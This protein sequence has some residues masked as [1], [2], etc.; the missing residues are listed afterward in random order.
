MFESI[1]AS[2]KTKFYVFFY[3]FNGLFIRLPAVLFFSKTEINRNLTLSVN[4][5]Y[6]ENRQHH[7][8]KH[9]ASF[10]SN[11]QVM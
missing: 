2:L 7:C 1:L 4:K 9:A 10:V 5:E 6:L 3:F 11:N 8:T